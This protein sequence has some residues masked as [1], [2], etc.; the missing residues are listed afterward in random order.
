ENLGPD[1]LWVGIFDVG[2]TGQV[3]HLTSSTPHGYLLPPAKNGQ[4]S[5]YTLGAEPPF[6]WGLGPLRWPADGPSDERRRSECL[7]VIAC[8]KPV[9]FGVFETPESLSPA[10]SLDG[11]RDM[12]QVR[13]LNVPQ[14]LSR[15]CQTNIHF[16][17]L[18]TLR[19]QQPLRSRG[20]LA[21]A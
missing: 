11:V 20:V 6:W 14:R 2:I 19:G 8:E 10:S 3:T 1:A 15:H 16:E 21:A 9:S 12:S 4:P 18:S 17:L 5:M 13:D 7:V